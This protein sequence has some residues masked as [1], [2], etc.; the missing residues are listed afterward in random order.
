MSTLKI[1]K[2]ERWE[3]II[4]LEKEWNDSASY[5]SEW[6]KKVTLFGLFHTDRI[7]HRT[8]HKL[9]KTGTGKVGFKSE[10]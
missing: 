2:D 9:P 6:R 5:S 7:Y 8:C 3:D 1:L 4:P 10:D